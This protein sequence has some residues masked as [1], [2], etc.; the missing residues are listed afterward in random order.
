MTKN[1]STVFFYFYLYLC[2]CVCVRGGGGGQGVAGRGV[3]RR[4]GA[5]IF[6]CDILL[7]PSAHCCKFLS[8]YFLSLTSYGVHKNSLR[9]LSHKIRQKHTW[10]IED[11]S[12]IIA[13]KV[14]SKYLQWLGSKCHFSILRFISV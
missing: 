14:L 12:R 8:K 9:N 1:P 7:Q 10:L 3:G 6:I 4:V 13:I 5:I 11:L 2:V